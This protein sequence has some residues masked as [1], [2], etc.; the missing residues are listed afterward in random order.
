MFS[1]EPIAVYTT[2]IGN[3]TLKFVWFMFERNSIE[4]NPTEHS[5]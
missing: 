1:N 3:V 4:T 5:C 2:G